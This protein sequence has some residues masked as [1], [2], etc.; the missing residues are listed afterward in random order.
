MTGSRRWFE[1]QDDA[2]LGYAVQLDE[3]V[4][5]VTAL[6]FG[7]VSAATVAARRFAKVSGQVPVKLR[8]LLVARVNEDED[9]VR[10]KVYVGSPTAGAWVSANS[11]TLDGEVYSIVGRV[12]EYRFSLPA[13]DTAQTDGDIDANVA[14]GP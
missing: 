6:G 9:T 1:Y 13:T 3:S 11:I 10:R 14:A 2:G 4:A 8:Y 12:G 5:E 7:P